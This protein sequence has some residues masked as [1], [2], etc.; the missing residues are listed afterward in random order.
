[1]TQ[2]NSDDLTRDLNDR[3]KELEDMTRELEDRQHELDDA[4]TQAEDSFTAFDDD[5]DQHKNMS[6]QARMEGD[7]IFFTADVSADIP[8]ML[9][10]TNTNGDIHVVGADISQVEIRADRS[11][12]GDADHT[13][14]FFQQIDNDVTL[15]PNW[16]FGSH[17]GGLANKLKSQLREGFKSSDWSSKDFKFG[18]DVSYDLTVRVPNHMA[19]IS[20]AWF[21]T[22]NGDIQ[23]SGVDAKLDVKTANGDLRVQGGKSLALH[24][25]NGDLQANGITGD[26]SAASANGDIRLSGIT[27]AIDAN[28]AAGDIQVDGATGWVTLR[29]ASGDI[30]LQNATVKGGRIVNVSGDIQVDA[31]FPNKGTFGFDSVSG[32]ITIRATVPAEGVSL[33]T[34]SV[35]GDTHAPGFTSTGKGHWVIGEGT[36]V[37]FSSKTVSG[38]IRIEATLDSSLT[39]TNEQ[40]RHAQPVDGEEA[41]ASDKTGD[42]NINLDIE[43]ERAKGWLKDIAS[44][45]NVVV[46]D[47]RSGNEP[48]TPPAPE[49]P[50]APEAPQTPPAPETATRRA[51]L[52]EK[53]KSGEISVDEA[54][55]ELEKNA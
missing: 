35:S 20:E 51:E 9:R 31:T 54:L 46:D 24:T 47:S 21:K 6:D 12:G 44:K 48:E 37:D 27:G 4:A 33:S 55:A 1:M 25:A 42:V 40:P 10:V 36:G 53:V 41:P 19:D 17:V 13:H 11:N 45:F 5:S 26:V 52:L 32:D 29:S 28:N 8:L 14:W 49:A 15:R 2:H 22:A 43:L 23:V 34:K 16:Q 18:L 3:I 39:L 50:K 30:R 38:D 7:S